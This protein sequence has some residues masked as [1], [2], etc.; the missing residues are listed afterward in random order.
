MRHGRL[1]NGTA[2]LLTGQTATSWAYVLLAGLVAL[3]AV[4]CSLPTAVDRPGAEHLARVSSFPAWSADGGSIYYSDRE[5]SGIT[6]VTINAIDVASGRTRRLAT[7][8]V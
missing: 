4:S 3:Q 2:L 8:P 6:Q 7:A 5:G 1:R